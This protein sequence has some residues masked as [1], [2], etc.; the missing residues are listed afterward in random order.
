MVQ[1][2]LV[3]SCDHLIRLGY[4]VDDSRP[5][6]RWATG[7]YFISDSVHEWCI[8]SLGPQYHR[9]VKIG[10]VEDGV[11]EN[12]TRM[13]YRFALDFKRP[14]DAVMFKLVWGGS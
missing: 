1:I 13:Q 10:I 2:L 6:I 9:K 5:F 11:D 14:G 12:G 3:K 4:K 7:V 8:E